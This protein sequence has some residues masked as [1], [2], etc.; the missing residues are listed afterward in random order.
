MAVPALN[1]WSGG[2][3]MRACAR[4]RCRWRKELPMAAVDRLRQMSGV[5]YKRV[6]CRIPSRIFAGDPSMWLKKLLSRLAASRPEP[7]QS[8][9]EMVRDAL[10]PT[11]TR[12]T[13]PKPFTQPPTIQ[14]RAK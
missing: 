6:P 2:K 3:A 8:E 14:K 12:S 5:R 1:A 13:P 4:F 7:Q 10:K 9:F 11:G